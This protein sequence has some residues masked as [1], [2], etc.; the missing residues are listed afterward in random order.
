MLTRASPSHLHILTCPSTALTAIDGKRLRDE[1]CRCARACKKYIGWCG[2]YVGPCIN[3]CQR[4]LDALTDVPIE[5]VHLPK[6]LIQGAECCW[7]SR[8]SIAAMLLQLMLQHPLQVALQVTPALR[9]GAARY[10][11]CEDVMLVCLQE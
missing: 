7:E 1:R 8:L 2:P 10:D 3:V 4:Q 5:G 6:R 11:S 9:C